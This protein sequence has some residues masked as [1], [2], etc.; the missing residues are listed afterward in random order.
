[1]SNIGSCLCNQVKF[2]ITR[3]IKTVYY[4]HCSLCRKQT[5][6]GANAA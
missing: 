6:T 5:G 2:S 4:C 1:M 3:E